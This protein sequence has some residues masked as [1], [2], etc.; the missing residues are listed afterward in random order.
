[1]SQKQTISQK[2]YSLKTAGK[3]VSSFQLETHT[4]LKKKAKTVSQ[5]MMEEFL[6][7]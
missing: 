1:M 7:R 3:P 6:N 5:E 4:P 2:R